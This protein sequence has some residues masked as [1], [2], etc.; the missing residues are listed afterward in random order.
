MQLLDSHDRYGTVSRFL[1][2]AVAALILWQL[3]GMVLKGALGRES[4]LAGVFVGMHGS[5]GFVIFVL[6]LARAGWALINLG[7]RPSYG[8]G[9]AGIAAK[10]GHLAL[11]VL[12]LL[13]P[14]I[15]LIR[16]YGSERAYQVFG[17][18]LFP[19]RPEG[20]AIEWMVN[21]GGSWHGFLGWAMA[22]L[23]LGHIAMA[24]IHA[25]LLRD[26]TIER[27]AGRA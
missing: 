4:A 9:P 19:A 24:I 22:A 26:N 2:W 13:V 23:I 1:H 7:R 3:L 6:V 11:Y 21:L 18:E 17:Y 25:R 16:A 5:L 20:Q 10:A 27:M 15:A 8:A 12:M 14:G